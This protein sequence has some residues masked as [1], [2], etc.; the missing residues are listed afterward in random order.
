MPVLDDPAALR[1]IDKGDMLGALAGLPAQVR[2]GGARGRGLQPRSQ[3]APRA[4]LFAGMGG[5]AM[6]AEAASL[7]LRSHTSLP[8]AVERS[9]A[10][11]GWA[12]KETLLVAVSYSGDTEETLAC[13]QAAAARGARVLAVTSGG[14]LAAWAEQQGADLVRV[15]SGLQ[16]R[17][18]LGHLAFTT[19][20]ALE[21][22]G[23]A[24]LG[25]EP[26]ALAARLEAARGDLAATTPETQNPAKRLARA[27]EGRIAFV[28]AAGPLAV[29]AQ[30]FATQLNENAEVLAHWAPLPEAHHNEVTAWFGDPALRSAVRP[31]V[32]LGAEAGS[33]LAVREQATVALLREAG[34]EPFEV[35]V[36]AG[37]VLEQVFQAIYVGDYAS[38]YLACLRG[39]DPTPVEPI[40]RLKARLAS[41]RGG[42][43]GHVPRRDTGSR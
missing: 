39:R 20:G 29:A 34:A 27:L 32:F 2:E 30:R 38:V 17:A 31:V 37:S 14:K 26:E 6:G 1:R 12:G 13:T 43:P 10:P 42:G 22:L 11:P 21:R 28:Y 33:P 24:R 3:A 9:Y 25:S 5:S 41:L 23:V 7:W 18:A 16:P 19:L 40:Q 15:P 36:P 4:V 8:C 35:A